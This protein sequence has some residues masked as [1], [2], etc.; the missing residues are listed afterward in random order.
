MRV[1]TREP[2]GSDVRAS[3]DSDLTAG[4]VRH[5]DTELR[6]G[7]PAP[8]DADGLRTAAAPAARAL[9]REGGTI[10]WRAD[11]AEQVRAIVELAQRFAA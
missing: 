10:A 8:L 2:S 1:E 11:N 6:V 4:E 3:I 9:R 5:T 7:A